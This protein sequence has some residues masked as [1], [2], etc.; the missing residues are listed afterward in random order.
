MH[1]GSIYVK[2]ENQNDHRPIVHISSN[3]FHLRKC[4]VLWICAICL[5]VCRIL[6]LTYISFTYCWNSVESLY[7]SGKIPLTPVNVGV[8][9]RSKSQG[10]WEIRCKNRFFRT[11]SSKIFGFQLPSVQIAK[12]ITKFEI[13]FQERSRLI[14]L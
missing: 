8:I 3:T 13:Q 12:R 1:S 9:L 11:S 10:Y 6:Y 7:F 14:K 4:F 5:P 2:V